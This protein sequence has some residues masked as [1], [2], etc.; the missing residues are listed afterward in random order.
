MCWLGMKVLLTFVFWKCV[1]DRICD[2]FSAGWKPIHYFSF[3]LEILLGT[4]V[5]NIS[6]K[7]IMVTMGLI[8]KVVGPNL[9]GFL[10]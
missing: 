4:T 8:S 10:M 2:Y 3:I 1:N 6:Y 5:Q 9:L 7:Q